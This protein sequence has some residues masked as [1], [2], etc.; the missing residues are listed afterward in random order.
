MMRR[1]LIFLLLVW[2]A[3][4]CAP[5]IKRIDLSPMPPILNEWFSVSTEIDPG[6]NSG[7]PT[8][9]VRRL[10][11][12]AVASD[13][14]R[15]MLADGAAG[16]HRYVTSVLPSTVGGTPAG[17]LLELTVAV[18]WID[19]SGV[20]RTVSDTRQV[21]VVEPQRCF[22]FGSA[23]VL[24]GWDSGPFS[25][26]RVGDSPPI[27]PLRADTYPSAWKWSAELNQPLPADAAGAATLKVPDWLQEQG[28]P[29]G[30]YWV[31]D[32]AIA[33]RRPASKVEFWMLAPFPLDV[34]AIADIEWR[35]SIPEYY[36]PGSH[37]S[38]NSMRQSVGTTWHYYSIDLPA[39]YPTRLV[40]GVVINAHQTGI[41][42]RIFGRP[43]NLSQ[44]VGQTV[45]IDDICLR[46]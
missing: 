4:G 17:A 16:N 14:P 7:R 40:N 22:A 46:P 12:P 2:L 6:N 1:R 25:R 3:G 20:S 30:S 27:T 41:R 5:V 29:S 33:F 19:T 13:G 38:M 37:V 10:E 28:W 31:A 9:T 8:L 44:Q 43:A 24:D 45:A 42:L 32:L 34:Q 36:E 39:T 26:A 21:R 35:S 15:P 11:P 23:A 18:P